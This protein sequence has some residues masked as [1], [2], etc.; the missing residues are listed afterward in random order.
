[1]KKPSNM[2]EDLVLKPYQKRGLFWY[3]QIHQMKLGGI[4]ADEMGL[5][6]FDSSDLI[7]NRRLLYHVMGVLSVK[8]V[9]L[10]MVVYFNFILFS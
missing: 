5:G 10:N 4:L 6:R 1:M 9:V 3:T 7:R 2:H 8:Q